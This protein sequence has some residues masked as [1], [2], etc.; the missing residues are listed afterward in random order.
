LLDIWRYTAEHWGRDQADR[1]LDRVDSA[2]E[3]L[4]DHPFLGSDCGDI[5]HGYRRFSVEQHRV[6]YIV[7]PRRVEVIRVLHSHRD[8]DGQLGV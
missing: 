4:R 6:F 8:I 2:L 5:R 7:T 1:Y 3:S